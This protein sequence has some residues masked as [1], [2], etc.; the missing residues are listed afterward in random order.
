MF[1]Q[2][3]GVPVES[4]H[5]QE[6]ECVSIL[7][8]RVK[9]RIKKHSNGSATHHKVVSRLDSAGKDTSHAQKSSVIVNTAIRR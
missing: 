2:R 1:W 3:V 6:F 8:P 9:N 5:A 4:V 7:K